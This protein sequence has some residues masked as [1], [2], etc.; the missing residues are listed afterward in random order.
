MREGDQ[1]RGAWFDIRV[2]APVSFITS[3][4]IPPLLQRDVC[5]HVAAI[6][7]KELLTLTSSIFFTSIHP[8]SP[9]TVALPTLCGKVMARSPKMSFMLQPWLLLMLISLEELLMLS[10][11]SPFW[12]VSRLA[13]HVTP[14][15][16]FISLVSTHAPLLPHLKKCWCFLAAQSKVV[17]PYSEYPS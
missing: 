6:L 11:T 1:G 10:A 5:L 16:G 17:F 2:G 8:A 7:P 14:S 9:V 3:T 4:L 12:T 15:Y 13:F